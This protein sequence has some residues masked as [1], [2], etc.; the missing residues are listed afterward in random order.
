MYN[1]KYGVIVLKKVLV[2]LLCLFCFCGCAQKS[3]EISEGLAPAVVVHEPDGN[4]AAGYRT[5]KKTESKDEKWDGFY[6]ANIN[7]KKFHL[8]NCESAKTITGKNL[9]KT[10][11]REELINKGYSPCKVCN[12]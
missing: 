8:S 7:S 2:I 1:Y 4:N 11:S 5:D 12:P 6:F 9:Y 10:D 3:A